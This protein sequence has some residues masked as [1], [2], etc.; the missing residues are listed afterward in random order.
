MCLRNMTTSGD[1]FQVHQG[2]FYL[3]LIPHAS[4]TDPPKHSYLTRITYS[5]KGL[6]PV[7][8]SDR[9]K[10]TVSVPHTKLCRHKEKTWDL[11]PPEVSYKIAPIQRPNECAWACF[12]N[13]ERSS[14]FILTK[15][16]KHVLTHPF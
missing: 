15:L 16:T 4:H 13:L 5:Q 9:A 7:L 10:K 6:P 11:D 8:T 2:N 1:Q 12:V 14:S 3:N